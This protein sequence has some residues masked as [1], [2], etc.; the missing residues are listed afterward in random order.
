VTGLPL[1]DHAFAR[2]SR[3]ARSRP[4]ADGAAAVKRL[5]RFV[6]AMLKAE[7]GA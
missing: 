4:C 5:R 6:H 2:L 7:V 1:F 3:A